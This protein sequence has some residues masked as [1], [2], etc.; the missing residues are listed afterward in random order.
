M[1]RPY[2]RLVS[3]YHRLYDLLTLQRYAAVH[4]DIAIF[5]KLP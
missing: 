2:P 4:L 1:F 3:E 5:V